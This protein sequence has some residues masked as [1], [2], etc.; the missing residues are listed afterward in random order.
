MGA[1]LLLRVFSGTS[2]EDHIL[3]ASQIVERLGGLTLAI[4]QVSAF[5]Q[6][7]QWSIDRLGEPLD[8]YEAQ[9]EKVLRHV[10]EDLWECGACMWT[11]VLETR[12]YRPSPCGKCRF[13]R[14]VGMEGSIEGGGALP[15][16]LGISDADSRQ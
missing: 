11:K 3:T 10:P 9:R 1:S 12:Q 4:N 14:C 13:S 8:T 16:P 6:Y 15:H 7:H 5:A 2:H